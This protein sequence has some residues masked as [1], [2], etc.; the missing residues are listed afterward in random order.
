[1]EPNYVLA[2]V[3]LMLRTKG[4]CQPIWDRIGGALTRHRKG[5]E[6]NTI[7]FH[8]AA[9]FASHHADCFIKIA[10]WFRTHIL[11]AFSLSL[12]SFS[13]SQ[14]SIHR[15]TASLSRPP[16]THDIDMGF[17]ASCLMICDVRKQVPGSH[18]HA[19]QTHGW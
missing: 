1:M 3:E 12:H 18:C 14:T 13:L 7:N 19:T 15:P 16:T 5:K 4:W 17:L 2:H 6:E 10:L 8:W 9:F 11:S